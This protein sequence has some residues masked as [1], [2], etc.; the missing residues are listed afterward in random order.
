MGQATP[1]GM[2]LCCILASTAVEK[3]QQKR[4]DNHKQ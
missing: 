1:E 3:P 2:T 4:E